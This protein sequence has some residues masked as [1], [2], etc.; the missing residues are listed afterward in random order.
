MKISW[1]ENKINEEVLTLADEQL[2]IIQTI[3][4]RKMTKFGHMLRRNNIHRLTLD[5]PLEGK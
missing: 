4:K 5:G 2:Y 3:Q 1:R